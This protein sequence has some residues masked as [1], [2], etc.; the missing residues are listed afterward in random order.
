VGD[1]ERGVILVALSVGLLVVT[2]A[3]L[4]LATWRSRAEIA[5]GAVGIAAG[6]WLVVRSR[7]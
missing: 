5:L 3:E 6:V 4:D 7:R 2:S 1:R